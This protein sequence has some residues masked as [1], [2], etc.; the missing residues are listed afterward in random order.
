MKKLSQESR[1][2]LR[3]DKKML[4]RMLASFERKKDNFCINIFCFALG[5]GKLN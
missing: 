1:M 5:A 3:L 2:K 4:A